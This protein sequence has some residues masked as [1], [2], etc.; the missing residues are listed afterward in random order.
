MSRKLYT[1]LFAW[2]M[3]VGS[4]AWLLYYD[5]RIGVPVLLAIWGNAALEK[6]GDL[7]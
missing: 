5:W 7:K 6:I 3:L 2:L 1:A 4:L